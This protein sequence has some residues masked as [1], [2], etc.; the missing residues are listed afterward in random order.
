MF[1][2]K[3]SPNQ[4]ELIEAE[5]IQRIDMDFSETAKKDQHNIALRDAYGRPKNLAPSEEFRQ[6][7]A[8]VDAL[9]D[10]CIEQHGKTID[11]IIEGPDDFLDILTKPEINLLLMHRLA[12]RRLAEITGE[13]THESAYVEA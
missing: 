7:S 12:I 11:A 1:R 2:P 13:P 5:Y 10:R 3:E 9:N 4:F 6:L 8:E